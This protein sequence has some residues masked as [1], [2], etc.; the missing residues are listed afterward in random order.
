MNGEI[1]NICLRT[2]IS[3]IVFAY[4][5]FV[6]MQ[7]RFRY[8]KVKTLLWVSALLVITVVITGIF[9]SKIGPLHEY[10][11]FGIVLWLFLA[12]F[13]LCKTIKESRLEI[14][15]IVLM[16]LNLYV[17]IM[18]TAILV[19]ASQGYI[20]YDTIVYTVV[21]FVI[22]LIYIPFLHILFFGFFK[23]VLNFGENFSFWKFIW[24]IPTLT[25]LIFY[26]KFVKGFGEYKTHV[27]SWDVMFIILWSVTTYAFY[28]VTLK[29]LILAHKGTVTDEQMK[30]IER[31][32]SMQEEQYKKL[33]ENN[34]SVSR[35]RHD[36]RHH[37][38]SINGFV[39]NQD[40]E[41]LKQYLE[42]LSPKYVNYEEVTVCP[43]HVVDIIL[44]HYGAMA[45]ANGI[46]MS[47]K[48]KIAPEVNIQDTDLC[49]VFGNLVENAVEACI[50]QKTGDKFIDVVTSTRGSQLVVMISNTYEENIR[51]ENDRYYSTK[52][53]GEGIGLFSVRKVVEKYS[54]F[55]NVE[56]NDRFFKVNLLLNMDYERDAD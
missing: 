37:L 46:Y 30:F 35:I 44:R 50:H 39:E 38:L 33:L 9:L 55:M 20:G 8:G 32:L 43:N 11:V 56:Y 13:I 48:A 15:F 52:H 5:V 49:I 54:G 23:Q 25:Y 18:T 40:M 51:V 10:M 29:M 21:T 42:M 26:I 53:E 12:W 36:W 1:A 28:S 14:L 41:S 45:K 6:P 34:D 31:Q 7:S 47:V 2:T 22:I 3:Y 16:A 19:S 4:F 27:G 24:I 17:N